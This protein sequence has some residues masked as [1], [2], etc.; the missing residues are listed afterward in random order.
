MPP[1]EAG[2]EPA[3]FQVHFFLLFVESGN[4]IVHMYQF[5]L[6]DLL[7]APTEE[8]AET[9]L[10]TDCVPHVGVL[11]DLTEPFLALLRTRVQVDGA[12]S[13]SNWG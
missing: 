1:Q 10:S 6:S 7:G 13:R 2:T 12:V 3:C 8:L 5:N 9:D 4:H 11:L